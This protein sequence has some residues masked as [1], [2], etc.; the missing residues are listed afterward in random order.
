MSY[1]RGYIEC[2]GCSV[3]N[4]GHFEPGGHAALAAGLKPANQKELNF[5]WLCGDCGPDYN[6]DPKEFYIAEFFENNPTC[7]R[8]DEEPVENWGHVCLECE[9]G[10]I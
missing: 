4:D 3:A 6:Y 7:D 5:F 2:D 8:C 9:D 10:V 1:N